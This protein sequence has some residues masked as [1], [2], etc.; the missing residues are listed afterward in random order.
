[1]Q[2]LQP[3]LKEATDLITSVVTE[4]NDAV[5]LAKSDLERVNMDVRAAQ[6][7]LKDVVAEA[8][9]AKR[10]FTAIT[11]RIDERTKDYK[12]RLAKQANALE[13]ATSDAKT[14][15]EALN[16]TILQLNGAK[17][18]LREAIDKKTA[19]EA[20]I[21][22]LNTKLA[23]ATE[24][25]QGLVNDIADKTTEKGKL[26]EAVRVLESTKNTLTEEIAGLET[27]KSEAQIKSEQE[28]STVDATIVER[29]K[30]LAKVEKKIEQFNE[31]ID[32]ETKVLD[33]KKRLIEREQTDINDAKRKMSSDRSLLSPL[34]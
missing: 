26:A 2:T 9:K 3:K 29:R 25:H 1:M 34:S 22:A 14:A 18:A 24:Q 13:R 17:K 21:E 8:E 33:A 12:D 23:T 19:V 32:T 30:E 7:R 20:E 15:Q 4:A 11:Q 5:T 6:Q 10:T 31:Y 28:L 27:K 16:K